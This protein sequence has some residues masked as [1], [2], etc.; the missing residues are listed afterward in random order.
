MLEERDASS[1]D[2]EVQTV[3]SPVYVDAMVLRDEDTDADGDT[4]DAGGGER[5]YVLHDANFNVTALTD[6]AGIVQER[7]LYDPY[8][9]RTVLNADWTVDTDGLSDF[10]FVHGHQGGRHDLAA[11]LVDFRNRQLHTS[12]GRWERQHP[13]PP[14]IDAPTVSYCLVHPVLLC[15]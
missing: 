8:G 2:V 12:P 15:R 7:F 10:A 6:V 3:W 4:Q 11:G 13:N 14:P 5:L 1:G 9:E